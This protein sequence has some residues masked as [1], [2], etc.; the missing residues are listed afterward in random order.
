M[1]RKTVVG[2]R[3]VNSALRNIR[4]TKCAIY[5]NNNS[6]S[7]LKN[8]P[9]QVIIGLSLSVTKQHNSTTKN[10]YIGPTYD[11]NNS[12]VSYKRVRTII[13]IA[14]IILKVKIKRPHLKWL[15]I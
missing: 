13:T 6:N 5:S 14:S 1:I 10:R 11:N 15:L 3:I 12:N 8:E 4:P 7:I 2:Y 9:I